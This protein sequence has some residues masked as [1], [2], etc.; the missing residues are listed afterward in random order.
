MSRYL[1]D[2]VAKAHFLP[3]NAQQNA[4]IIASIEQYEQMN[5]VFNIT[6]SLRIDP[7]LPDDS[8]IFSLVASGRVDEFLETIKGKEFIWRGRDP[9]GRSLLHVSYFQKPL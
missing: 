8:P 2:L 5:G 3:K 4:L 7:I 1:C 6:P 9:S